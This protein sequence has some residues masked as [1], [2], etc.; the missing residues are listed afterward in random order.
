[1]NYNTEIILNP[2]YQNN[3]FNIGGAID[4]SIE[5]LLGSNIVIGGGSG[6]GGHVIKY[7]G[8]NLP[9][10]SILEFLGNV[11]VVDGA[12]STE[13][14][15]PLQVN[16]DWNATTGLAKIHNKP[17]IPN[18]SYQ[19]TPPTSPNL[20][21]LWVS[22]VT[23]IQYQ[24][25]GSWVNFNLQSLID[26]Q[27]IINGGNSTSIHIDI[28]DGGFSNSITTNIINGGNALNN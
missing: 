13:V 9:T 21:D 5:I 8:V 10:K 7:N 23:L 14:S 3:N 27:A 22:T 2:V 11:N 19:S 24:W 17:L 16:S 20:N 1:M 4:F 25:I 15:I 28:A 12:N 26:I 18:I 6:G